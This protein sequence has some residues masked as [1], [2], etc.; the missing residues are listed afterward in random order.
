MA[1]EICKGINFNS[2]VSAK[3]W[4]NTYNYNIIKCLYDNVNKGACHLLASLRELKVR[5][6]VV[7]RDT[8]RGAL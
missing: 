6:L 1:T 5:K 8:E 3:K 7:T 2:L 4:D